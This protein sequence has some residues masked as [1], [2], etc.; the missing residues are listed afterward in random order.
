MSAR[1]SLHIKPGF[2]IGRKLS[3]AFIPTLAKAPRPSV[4][5][6]FNNEKADNYPGRNFDAVFRLELE[7]DVLASDE[8]IETEE[9]NIDT[10]HEDHRGWS[11]ALEEDTE[12]QERRHGRRQASRRKKSSRHTKHQSSRSRSRSNGE[13]LA[14]YDHTLDVNRTITLA[15]VPSS[16]P[17]GRLSTKYQ[18]ELSDD[19][20]KSVIRVS[21]RPLSGTQT[22]QSIAVPVGDGYDALD[23]MADY[24]FRF[25]CEK[26][27]WFRRPPITAMEKR[28]YNSSKHVTTGVCIRAKTGVQRAYPS[29]TPGLAAFET[30]VTALNPEVAFKVKSPIVKTVMST[31][32]TPDMAEFTIDADTRI[33]ILDELSHLARARKHQYA[34]FIRD[35]GVLCVWADTVDNIIAA[36]ESL[37]QSLIDFIWHQE[38]ATQKQ[39]FAAH[40]D[41]HAQQEKEALERSFQQG[42]KE[43]DTSEKTSEKTEEDTAVDAEDLARLQAKQRWKERPVM[44][45]D[46]V[47]AG[48]TVIII[49]A[50]LSLGTLIKEYVLDG[51]ATR[52]V[53]MAVTPLLACVAACLVG[54]FWQIFGP[55]RQV[56]QNSAYYSAVAPKR[57]MGEL[58]HVTVWLP[59][60]KESLE[61][62]IMPTIESLKIA[63]SVYERQGGSVSILV[64]DDGL[65]LISPDD[66]ESRRNFYYDNNMAFVARPGHGVDGFERRGRF[67]KASNMNF[68]IQ[69]SLRVEEIMDDS[70]PDAHEGKGG[71]AYF[72]HE[73]DELDLYDTA[74]ERAQEEL[75]GRAWAAGNIRIGSYILIIDSDTRVPEDCFADAVSEFA[76]SPEVAVIQHSSGVMQ[77][78][79]HFFENGIAHFTRSIQLAISFCCSNGSTAPFVGHNAFLRWSALQEII[80]IEDGVQKIWSESHVSEDFALSLALQ[81]KGYVLRWATYSEDKFEEGVSLTCDDEVNRW[82][83]YAW[84]CSELIFHPLRYWLFRGPLT[85]LF[86]QYLGSNIPIHCKIS[87]LAYIFSYYAIACS[88]PLTVLNYVLV[89]FDL[90]IDNF[91]LNGWKI[92]FVCILLFS[93]LSNVAAIVLRYRLKIK[94]TGD[95]AAKQIM[96]IPF[97]SIFFTG[98]SMQIG[99]ALI[100]HMVGYQMTWAATLKTVEV[101][102]F[103]KEVPAILR[104]FRFSLPANL[105]LV[106]GMIVTTS[107]VVPDG[108]R[109]VDLE[110]VIPLALVSASHILYPI[111]LNPWFMHFSF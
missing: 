25:G 79:N 14:D 42:N 33:Q 13:S 96:F 21:D 53:L 61:E 101:S 39:G 57:G 89:G 7:A 84:G 68:A 69:L 73:Q 43:M 82:Q 87:V 11:S 100:C 70:R 106:A 40:L 50:L 8:E 27:K 72:W 86:R 34:A 10:V 91:Y 76:L 80:F 110:A 102:N 109:V 97:F 19:D 99:S 46:A 22:T 104:K 26:K 38:H 66:V 4:A 24:L 51:K 74:L 107:S 62:V 5:E 35:E 59:V 58:P 36:T 98:L 45:Y 88:W 37:E 78:A 56:T 94:N 63:Q 41:A 105:I 55:I 29:N 32:I 23:V 77:V 54:G 92:A 2:D 31:C 64:C 108:W 15:G 90:P 28:R 65:Q 52:F 47:S 81:L 17:F 20:D 95:F 16:S 3:Q 60:Y 18:D 93:G 71:D 48:L 67:K 83:K 30:A 9:Q 85:P 12:A 44:L 49:F 6:T 111:A 1:P 103:F 75:E